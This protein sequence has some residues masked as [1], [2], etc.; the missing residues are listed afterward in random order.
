MSSEFHWG[1]ING[2]SLC[3]AV[4]SD[5]W[6]V[7]AVMFIAYLGLGIAGSKMYTPSY[8]SSSVVAVY[9]FNQMYTLE[10]SSNALATVSA[11]NEVFISEM[12]STGLQ[13]RLT[14]SADFSLYSQQIDGT[15][16]LMLS[17]S[18]SSPE[19]A[20][21]TLRTALD[22]FGEISSRLVG[23]NHL[24]ILSEPDFPLSAS[25]ASRILKY[26]SVLTLFCGFAMGCFL[27]LMYVMRKTY[28]SPSAIRRY[29]NNV[30]F[31]TVPASAS[32][33]RSRKNK[34]KSVGVPNQEAI[35]KTALE[36][37]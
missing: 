16:I 8:T 28:K 37:L 12:F 2:K 26:R 36:L 22:Y 14:E 25:N 35:R 6:M 21:V 15:Y 32:A 33:K 11:A 19:N 34:R 3:K 10:A 27:V 5:L 20:Y 18:S 23:D 30:Q 1:G 9:P 29:Y 7:F 24:E 13:E 4:L 17:A 31:F